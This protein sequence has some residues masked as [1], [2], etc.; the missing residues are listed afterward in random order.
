MPKLSL[1]EQL[2]II[3]AEVKSNFTYCTD[4]EQY[5]QVELWCMPKDAKFTGDCEDFALACRAQCRKLGIPSRLVFCYANGEGHCVLEVQGW[6]L[7]NNLSSVQD[8]QEIK[9][10]EWVSIS[11]Y[12]AGDDWHEIVKGEK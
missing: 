10:Y 5:G 3:H 1:K 9:G 8:W 12:E 4:L 2:D 7:D 6:I 11:G